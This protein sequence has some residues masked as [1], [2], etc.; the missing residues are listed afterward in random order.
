MTTMYRQILTVVIFALGGCA[1]GIGE[2]DALLL[3]DDALR[4]AVASSS[5]Q[6]PKIERLRSNRFSQGWQFEYRTVTGDKS[7]VYAVLVGDDKHVE[8]SRQG[9][10]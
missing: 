6:E 8:V 10:D 3:A 1:S 7:V 5:T 4:K 2:Q 9:P